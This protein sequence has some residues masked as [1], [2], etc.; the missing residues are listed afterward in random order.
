MA[1]TK[2]KKS[3]VEKSLRVVTSNLISLKIKQGDIVKFFD[4]TPSPLGRIPKTL[5]LGKEYEA[6]GVRECVICVENDRGDF[7]SFYSN[8]FKKIS[9]RK[10]KST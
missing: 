10:R 7:V 4:D 5:T 9:K 8:R 2:K 3:R 1:Q 6:L